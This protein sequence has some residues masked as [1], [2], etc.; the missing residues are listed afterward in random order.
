MPYKIMIVDD[1]PANLRTLE[2]LFRPDYQVV[3]AASGQEA[4]ALLEKHDV[5][6]LISDQRMPG[7]TGIELMLKT[8][9]I[10]PQMV[11]LL[12]TGYTDVGA[13]I[14]ALN[15]GLVYRYLTKP[16]N[17]NDLRNTVSR[18]LEHFEVMKS[19]HTLGMENQRLKARLKE[20]SNLASEELAPE[21]TAEVAATRS[22]PEIYELLG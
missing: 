7:M 15:S 14:E 2:R 10:R 6:L 12:L 5:A 13:L 18:A 20:I 19:K 17:N 3:T 22:E 4:L 9:A 16:W 8:V 1:E 21:A 11:K